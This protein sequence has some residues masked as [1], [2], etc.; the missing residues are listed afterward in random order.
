MIRRWIR[1]ISLANK[2]LLLFG[3]AVVVIVGAALMVP[4]LRMGGLVEAGE[5]QVSRELASAW[6]ADEGR[7]SIGARVLTLDAARAESAGDASLRRALRALERGSERA[8]FQSSSWRGAAKAYRYVRALR[9]EPAGPI[10]RVLVLDRRSDGAGALLLIN[11][12]YLFTA[13]SLVLALAVLVFYLITRYLILSPVRALRETAERVREGDLSTRSA[14]DTG[15]EFEELAQTFNLMLGDLQAGQDRLRAINTALDGKLNELAE[16]NLQLYDANRVKSEFLAN[17]SHELRTPLNSIIGFAELLKEIAEQEA[18][19]LASM[20]QPAPPGLSKRIRY[21]D[22]ILTAGRNL[23][24]MING[25]LEMARIEAGRVTLHIEPMVVRDTCQGLLGL[26]HPLAARRGVE[27]ELDAAADLPLVQTDVKKFQ[28]IVFNFLSNAVKFVT[29]GDARA[30]RPKV[31]LRAEILRA[32]GEG[33]LRVSV[34]D[35]GPGIAPHDQARI[36]DKFQQLDA[37]HTRESTGTGLGLA[38]AKELATLLHAEIQVVSDVGRGA[39]FSIIM[40]LRIDGPALREGD[41]A[42][43]DIA[44]SRVGATR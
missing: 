29:A 36:F 5:L 14:I 10:A 11:T 33:K 41:R 21:L 20:R 9:D 3:G 13:G 24:E 27:L 37:S 26:I 23:L 16:S 34:I 18:A 25:L 12:I 4:W 38:I 32:E 15:D 30:V 22:N 19:E 44:S 31:T 2:C 17:V 28:Q 7:S 43:A 8:D 35:N 6:L 42:R 39:M 1:G 40:P